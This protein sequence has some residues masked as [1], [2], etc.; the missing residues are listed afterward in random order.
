MIVGWTWHQKRYA[1]APRPQL[2]QGHFEPNV[3]D[4]DDGFA[5]DDETGLFLPE[6]AAKA[7]RKVQIGFHK[8]SE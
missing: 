2:G 3:P 1:L 8:E 4:K 7:R 5:V 6:A